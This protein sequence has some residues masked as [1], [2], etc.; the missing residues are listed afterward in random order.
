MIRRPPRSTLSSSSAAS[1]VY[2]RQ[3]ED[4][5][6]D[7]TTHYQ[8]L[9]RATAGPLGHHNSMT[10]STPA[11]PTA[12]LKLDSTVA[13]QLVVTVVDSAGR[14]VHESKVGV[15]RLSNPGCT[16][17]WKDNTVVATPDARTIFTASLD[18]AQERV[19][20]HPM[21][22]DPDTP[23]QLRLKH[24]HTDGRSA[25]LGEI[26]LDMPA[27][28]DPRDLED[29]IRILH[30]NQSTPGRIPPALS[31]LLN[32]ARG[33]TTKKLIHSILEVLKNGG[34]SNGLEEEDETLKYKRRHGHHNGSD[35]PSKHIFFRLRG[36]EAKRN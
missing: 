29:I 35:D 7:A 36:D 3:K 15:P 6:D 2:K 5:G 21:A 19:I 32:T 11:A 4:S 17:S 22:M 8:R 9:M 33:G 27:F 1:D 24:M 25:K 23:H 30:G 16:V 18:G 20:A 26:L 10:T 34:G 31:H 12:A 13:H 14:A 28:I